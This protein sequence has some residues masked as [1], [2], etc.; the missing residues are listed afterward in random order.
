MAQGCALA[1][2]TS[3]RVDEALNLSLGALPLRAARLY[4]EAIR[5]LDAHAIIPLA[6]D[7]IHE[8]ARRDRGVVAIQH[9]GHAA[10]HW[11]G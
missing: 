5:T 3:V 10:R 9:D 4:D 8:G 11:H 7:E 1:L 2:D 6:V